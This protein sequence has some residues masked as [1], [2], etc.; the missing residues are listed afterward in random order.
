MELTF[1]TAIE[2]VLNSP[3]RNLHLNVFR[4][5][6]QILAQM[7]NIQD[8][9]KWGLVELTIRQQGIVLEL[10]FSESKTDND[11]NFKRFQDLSHAN[12]FIPS[13]DVSDLSFFKLFPDNLG[14]VA[15]EVE[16]RKIID[17]VYGK[18]DADFELIGY[19]LD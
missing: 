15:I 19:K 2:L 8:F 14:S 10:R 6:G 17:L 18:V 11:E 9:N 4:P 1:L 5:D 3:N 12:S 13:T 16:S 7:Y